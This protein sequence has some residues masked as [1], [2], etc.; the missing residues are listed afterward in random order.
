MALPK[1]EEKK[2]LD[3]LKQ[4]AEASS[5]VLNKV[6]QRLAQIREDRANGILQVKGVGGV[7]HNL[8][9]LQTQLASHIASLV[10]TVAEDDSLEV[11]RTRNSRL[12]LLRAANGLIDETIKELK[13]SPV[14]ST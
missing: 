3:A 14:R 4:L 8:R 5:K 10:A 9:D 6:T 13:S 11:V 7:T 2:K 12:G 1:A